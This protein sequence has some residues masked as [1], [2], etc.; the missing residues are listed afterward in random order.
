MLYQSAFSMSPSNTFSASLHSSFFPQDRILVCGIL[1]AKPSAILDSYT[2]DS[3]WGMWHKMRVKGGGLLVLPC[4][5]PTFTIA[6]IRLFF[7]MRLLT[8]SYLSFLKCS[9]EVLHTQQYHVI[10]GTS[11]NRVLHLLMQEWIKS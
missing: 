6:S 10:C 3:L 11:L 5:P 7:S 2:S 4:F 1:Q 9:M 8:P